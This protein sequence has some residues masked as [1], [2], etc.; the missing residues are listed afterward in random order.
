MIDRKKMVKLDLVDD[1]MLEENKWNILGD[2]WLNVG[3][4]N[5][6]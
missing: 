5:G 4:N 2:Y 3:L 6:Y 1:D